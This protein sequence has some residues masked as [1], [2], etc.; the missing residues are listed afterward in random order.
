MPN[1]SKNLSCV[2]L[3]HDHFGTHLDHN[4]KTIDKELELQ[5]F[6]YVGGILAELW[7]KLVIDDHP[8]T[9]EFVRD[10]TSKITITKSEEWKANHVREYLLQIVK[11]TDKAVVL[12]S[13][14]P[15]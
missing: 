2:I 14:Q 12:P 7:S 15:T 10:T 13:N 5:S 3:P 4:N 6:E 1:L 8:V 11:C 9:D